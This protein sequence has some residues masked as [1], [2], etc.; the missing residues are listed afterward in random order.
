MQ[1]KKKK[2]E[3]E[4]Y[5]TNQNKITSKTKTRKQHLQKIMLSVFSVELLWLEKGHALNCVNT[6]FDTI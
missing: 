3:E 6:Q 1:K 4:E 2:E 5:K